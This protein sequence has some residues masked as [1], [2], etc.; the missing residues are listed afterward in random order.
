MHDKQKWQMK[1]YLFWQSTA[2][3]CCRAHFAHYVSL[4]FAK[5][6]LTS[7]TVQL[8]IHI[9]SQENVKDSFWECK[10]ISSPIKLMWLVQEFVAK[11]I[12]CCGKSGIGMGFVCWF[13]T[14]SPNICVFVFMDVHFVWR[15]VRIERWSSRRK[16]EKPDQNNGKTKATIFCLH[17]RS[18]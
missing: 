18:V 3:R 12:L 10:W 11:Y 15:E 6:D 17:H 13:K 4:L 5:L 1:S 14:F 2:A 9:L 7:M 16:T 8:H